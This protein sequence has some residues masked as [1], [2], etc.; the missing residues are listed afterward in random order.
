[1]A[2]DPKTSTYE[3]ESKVDMSQLREAVRKVFAYDP[4]QQSITPKPKH[5]KI[6][7]KTGAS[8]ASRSDSAAS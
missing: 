8:K 3:T 6:E 2:T 7:Q 1:M 5:R 4:S